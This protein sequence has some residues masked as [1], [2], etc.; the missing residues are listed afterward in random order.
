MKNILYA[1]VAFCAVLSAT[2]GSSSVATNCAVGATCPITISS[3]TSSTAASTT[4]GKSAAISATTENIHHENNNN[5][6]R[7]FLKEKPK[8][9]QTCQ[10]K[11]ADFDKCIV[12]AYQNIFST[13]KHGIDGVPHS[14]PID[15][16]FVHEFEVIEDRENITPIAVKINNIT[17]T[18]LSEA[19]VKSVN[20]KDNEYDF[21]MTYLVPKIRLNGHY[22]AKGHVLL[23]KLDTSGEMFMEILEGLY[24]VTTKVKLNPLESHKFFNLKALQFNVNSIKDLH[25][26]FDNLFKDKVLNDNTNAVFNGSWRVFFDIFK[27]KIEAEINKVLLAHFRS[28][29]EQ[30][31]AEFFIADVATAEEKPVEHITAHSHVHSGNIKE[32][33]HLE[34]LQ[35]HE[36][37]GS[38]KAEEK[39]HKLH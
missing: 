5:N 28:V 13:W 39:E 16:L 35:K 38:S 24:T 1:L 23:L 7:N 27:P 4:T 33:T 15:P 2:F 31:P 12:N 11:S 14:T 34:L 21:K 10:R 9:L 26:H 25:L 20:F 37:H 22:T 6:K 30:V 19:K 3:T 32:I 17:V 18:G 8:E 36:S 29:F